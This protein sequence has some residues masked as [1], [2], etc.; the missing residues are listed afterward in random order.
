MI[1]HKGHLIQ[2]IVGSRLVEGVGQGGAVVDGEDAIAPG[3]NALHTSRKDSATESSNAFAV[4]S[5]AVQDERGSPKPGS[6]KIFKRTKT[7]PVSVHSTLPNQERWS[8]SEWCVHVMEHEMIGNGNVPWVSVS[9]NGIAI[10]LNGP[11]ALIIMPVTRKYQVDFVLVEDFNGASENQR[12][13]LGNDENGACSKN[14]Y[15]A[16]GISG[17][18]KRTMSVNNDPRSLGSIDGSQVV[19]QPSNLLAVTR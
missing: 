18:I 5:C 10:S 2:N 19:L 16:L 12:V 14:A 11:H 4:S 6:A 17:A 7:R 1:N 9:L 15:E 13:I 8:F 3:T